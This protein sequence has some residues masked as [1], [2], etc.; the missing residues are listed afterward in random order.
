MAWSEGAR[1][2]QGYAGKRPDHIGSC[3]PQEGIMVVKSL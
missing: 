3:G 1:G 2:R